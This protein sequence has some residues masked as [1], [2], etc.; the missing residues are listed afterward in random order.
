MAYKQFLDWTPDHPDYRNEGLVE[1]KN[2]VPSFKSYKPTKGLAP[3]STNALSNRCQGFASFKS[4][5][6]NITSFAGDSTKLY[7]YLAN[8]FTDVSGGTTFSTPAD[9]DWQFTQ[10]GNYIIA[11]N[12]ANTPQVWQL[13]S[14]TAWANLGGSPPTYWHTAV[15][16]NFV[17]S[18]WQPTNRNKL[19]WSAIG[20][21]ASWTVG[22]DQS[23]EETLFDTSEITGIVG[24][25]F[26]IILCVN[27]I[28]QLNFVGGSSI[29][30]I[31]AIEQE[32]GA[33]A[34][35][36]IQTVGSETFFLSQDGFCKTNGESTTLIGENKI[37]KW[38]DDSLDQSNI[39]RI[40]S[41]HDP[42]NKLIFWS[43]PTTNSSGGNPDRILCYN[44]SAD[45][46]SYID[47]ATQ[48]IS[49][50]FT[51]GT[52][53]EALDNISTDIE[54]FTDSFDSRIWQ[55]GTLFFSAFD[56]NNKFGTFSGSNLEATL[57][58]GEQE[59]ADGKRTF[60][61]S[62]NPV[63]DV[64][65]KVASGTISITGTTVN[66]TG[67]AFTTQLTVGD[68]I[69]V[70][71]VSSQ[72]NNAKFIVATI[73]NDTL[74]SIVVAPDQNILNVTFLGYTPS[75]INLQSR[76]RA[77]GTVKESGFTTCN[78]NGVA[79]F[80]QSGKYHKIEVKIP[81][82]AT[83]ENGMGVEIY[84]SLDGVQ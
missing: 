76:E 79:S 49:S 28:F 42:L 81:A 56:G 70:N 37:D 39:L 22:T 4:S 36:S 65:P 40:T 47:V 80:R 74:L 10:F 33:I 13:D 44:Y 82:N 34:H 69:R 1:A 18:G 6:G 66:G 59:Y 51:T 14:S 61:T 38:F 67:T 15:V 27:K 50:A 19:H 24:G 3:V 71:D 43:Y 17:V 73:V 60:I 62:I 45:R 54:T 20:N 68:V 35:G 46:W 21:H 55:G 52:T 72:F 5:A 41:G 23:D 16:R 31:R 64:Q 83:W 8:A 12:G 53:L 58:I 84:A 26:G 48:N 2:V 11:S 7:R 75:Q 63:I 78:D 77:G 32:R 29:F 9:N 30:Q 57:S 25:E